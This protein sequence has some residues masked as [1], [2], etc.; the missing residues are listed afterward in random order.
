MAQ[1]ILTKNNA[2]ST[3]LAGITSGALSVSCQAGH[4]ARFDSPGAGQ[5]AKLTLYNSAGLREI[6]HVTARSGDTLTIVRAQEGTTARAWNAIDGMEQTATAA[7]LNGL[8]QLDRT[9][10]ITAVKTFSQSPI[11]PTPTPG[12]NTTKASST[13]FVTGAITAAKVSPAF[14]G[15]PTAPTAAVTDDSTTLATTA[16]VKDLL[17]AAQ[18]A[19]FVPIANSTVADGHGLGVV[20]SRFSAHL[21]CV[22]TD[23][24]YA[25]G[26][27]VDVSTYSYP[28]NGFGVVLADATNIIYS[29][30]GTFVLPHKSTTTPTVL[31]LSNWNMR[32]KAWRH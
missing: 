10:T 5:I 7:F 17:I 9:E 31:T 27:I 6:V 15:T 12:D 21:V 4:G 32:L 2:V 25:V 22:T 1:E 19:D 3:L 24:G 30:S 13:A 18:P 28:G 26:N 20:P 29:L 11:I 8:S 16:H 23:A 14:S